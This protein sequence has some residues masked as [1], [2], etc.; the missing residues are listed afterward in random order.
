MQIKRFAKCTLLGIIIEVQL[1]CKQ[2]KQWFAIQNFLFCTSLF[3]S[4]SLHK[5]KSSIRASTCG[6]MQ[7]WTHFWKQDFWNI[8]LWKLFSVLDNCR[9][10]YWVPQHHAHKLNVLQHLSYP[11]I[12]LV[13]AWKKQL[14]PQNE[15]Q[16]ISLRPF[17]WNYY[18]FN[19][20]PRTGVIQMG[21]KQ[22]RYEI[23]LTWK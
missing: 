15:F 2:G 21:S 18:V 5:P 14:S 13:V 17:W 9:S 16:T 3:F 12:S 8:L 19:L 1:L 20:Q 6:E 22:P 7:N 10:I 23:L 11:V 4:Q